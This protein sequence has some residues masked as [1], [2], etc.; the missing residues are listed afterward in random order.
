MFYYSNMVELSEIKQTRE[1]LGLP[2]EKI[3]RLADVFNNK[4]INIEVG[5]R[6]IPAIETLKNI[7]KAFEVGVD[8]LLK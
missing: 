6:D 3:A 5:K 1:D 8:D 2:Y 7:V 4:L